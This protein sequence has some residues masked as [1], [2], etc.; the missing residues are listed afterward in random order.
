[1]KFTNNISEAYIAS[2]VLN[3]PEDIIPQLRAEGIT[4]D[5]FHN[6]LPKLI[7]RLAGK[8]LDEDRIH[9]ISQL[10]WTDEVKGVDEGEVLSHDMSKIRSDW[11]GFEFM[12]NH[13]KTLKTMYATRFAQKQLSKALQALEE[14]ETP[15]EISDASR[16]TGE[17]IMAILESQSGYKDTKQ[18]VEEFADLL[19]AIHKDKTTAGTP[20]GIYQL[21]QI[22][23]GLSQNELWIIGAQTSGGKTALMLQIAI[24]FLL[25]GKRVLVFSLETEA[26]M[27]H[28][29]LAAN[30]QSVDM[31]RI[32]GKTDSPLIK[33]DL[34][35]LAGYIDEM[36]NNN[37]LVICDEDSITLESIAAKCQ[38]VN[39]VGGFDLILVDYIQLVSLT[40]TRDKARH[41]QVAEVTRTMKQLAKRYKCPV[42]T[43]TQ[44]NDDGRVRESRAIA[45]DADVLLT[46][47]EDGVYVSKNRSGERD[48]TLNLTLNG[49]YQRFE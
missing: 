37:N 41:E 7:W 13:L 23:G 6:Y 9:E 4:A 25:L 36:K 31:G 39:D 19:R 47:N 18:S 24:N 44:L 21:D 40:N 43:A 15:E 22:T 2:G 32:L 45:H 12:K 30:N 38:Q 16:S 11:C 35:K 17:G 14:G 34:I 26:N 10:E 49:S 3:E 1:M 46:I 5:Y 29:R 48:K 28:A 42:L 20:T 8:F 27:I 33:S